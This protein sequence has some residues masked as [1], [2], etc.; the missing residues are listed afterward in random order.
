MTSKTIGR[1]ANGHEI[2]F[3]NAADRAALTA[4]LD[5]TV[6]FWQDD[7]TKYRADGIG[8]WTLD[9]IIFTFAEKPGGQIID[10]KNNLTTTRYKISI[11][12][13]AT[14]IEM[15]YYNLGASTAKGLYFITNATSDAEADGKLALVGARRFLLLGESAVMLIDPNAPI[16]R[17]DVI[18]HTAD[19][20]GDGKLEILARIPA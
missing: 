9:N 8:G 6:Q 14:A 11:P 4:I 3:G 16:T 2:K 10:E 20:S 17:I 18:A 12:S 5:A 1:T 7:G 15:S 19:V 13:G